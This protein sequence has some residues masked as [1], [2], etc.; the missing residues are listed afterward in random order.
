MTVSELIR[1]LQT[2]DG[3]AVVRVRT[4]RFGGFMPVEEVRRRTYDADT[5]Y[6]ISGEHKTYFNDVSFPVVRP[7]CICGAA[8]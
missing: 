4:P 8:D 7:K 3:D 2:F 5:A 6:V 1:R